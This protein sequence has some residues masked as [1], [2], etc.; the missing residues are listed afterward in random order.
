MGFFCPMGVFICSTGRSLCVGKGLPRPMSF[1][2]R[3]SQRPMLVQSRSGLLGL[4]VSSSPSAASSPTAQEKRGSLQALV[5]KHSENL[6]RARRA[7]VVA[8]LDEQKPPPQPQEKPKARKPLSE[9]WK[10]GCRL[11]RQFIFGAV[12][13]EHIQDDQAK[14]AIYY[15]TIGSRSMVSELYKVWAKLDDDHS[16]RV[17]IGE[18]RSFAERHIRN[19][20]SQPGVGKAPTMIS[21]DIARFI[22]KLC[23]RLEKLLLSKKSSFVIEDMMRLCWP[24]A[25]PPDL[26]LMRQWCH[27][28]SLQKER[29]RF[30]AP[31]VM[32]KADYEGLTSVFHLYSSEGSGLLDIDELV[33]N[34]ITD[35]EQRQEWQKTHSGGVSLLDFCELLCP[36]GFR[37]SQKSQIGSLPDGRRVVYDGRLGCW[38]LLDECPD[39]TELS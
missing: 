8:D 14:D 6:P 27:E 26:K 29:S 23:E 3:R 16:G 15:E 21:D 32:P 34:G 4:M 37:A 19:R 1:D 5:R 18:F 2:F 10:E 39:S 36:D 35:E 20:T 7:S 11:M 24:S 31:P 28:Q 17:D 13:N 12:G 25:A 30:K 9:A 38:R 22:Q 33:K